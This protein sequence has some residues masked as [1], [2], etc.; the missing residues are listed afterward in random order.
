MPRFKNY[1]Q[2]LDDAGSNDGDNGF[3][4]MD[5]RTNPASLTAGIVS[6]SR[7]M[8]LDRAT[9]KP[10]RGVVAQ[11]LGIQLRFPPVVIPF[12]LPE[13]GVVLQNDYRDGA[14]TAGVYRGKAY[15]NEPITFT[16]AD[17]D[18]DFTAIHRG[19][20]YTVTTDELQTE[21]TE[22]EFIVLVFASD[23][24]L[25]DAEEGVIVRKFGIP[26]VEIIPDSDQISVVQAF[27][28]VFIFRGR[29]ER[30]DFLKPLMWDGDP[31][32][33]FELAPD[34]EAYY[35]IP[36][37][38]WAL[39]NSSRMIVPLEYISIPIDSLNVSAQGKLA[40]AITPLDHGLRRGMRIQVIDADTALLNGEKIITE[41]TK[42][43]YETDDAGE[44]KFDDD[45]NP[46]IKTPASFSYKTNID[47]EDDFT[48]T[49]GAIYGAFRARDEYVISGIL[50][51]LEYDMVGS[52]FRINKG[53]ADWL[54]GIAP[55]Q[56]DSVIV[57]MRKSIYLHSNLNYVE[58]SGPVIVT[59]EVGCL[60]RNTIA[61]IGNNIF[62]LS[63]EG[64]YSLSIAAELTLRGAGE[65]LSAD[66]DDQIKRINVTFAH[67][68]CAIFC[69]NRYYLAVPLDNSTRNN[70]I[71]IYN[72]INQKWESH[73][74]YPDSLYFDKLLVAN[75]RGK[76]RVFGVSREGGIVLMEE[77]EDGDEVGTIGQSAYEVSPV[78]AKLITRNY[79]FNSPE[80]KRVNRM[81][82]EVGYAK[83]DKWS[84]QTV[85][86]NPD[87]ESSVREYEH[88]KDGET[89]VRKAVRKN[90]HRAKVIFET[91][92]GRPELRQVVLEGNIKSADNRRKD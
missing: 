73:D 61:T 34:A 17:G 11:N 49:S 92:Q 48:D 47:V 80:L 13:E 65:P 45:D 6:L 83:G 76:K 68:A 55:Y 33:Q 91:T 3:V 24:Y 36:R 44:T 8:R 7:N 59:E 54:V 63:D 62:F 29:D 72:T 89:T 70:A 26:D 12:L 22:K 18:F 46:I 42:L 87:D 25:F 56:N 60:S 23:I 75:S 4:G 66:I 81:Q 57:F 28:N 85:L 37:A 82:L 16:T 64:V 38:S 88:D 20:E 74:N 52:H 67:R 69:D 41:V 21:L 32:T 14:R 40:T 71:F 50:E 35:S 1:D 19:R 84:M 90:A 31:E 10:R 30:G 86:E 79:T 53:S 2:Y 51:P 27:D 43:E 39:Y 15:L 58:E 9:A 77:R 78:N 5:T